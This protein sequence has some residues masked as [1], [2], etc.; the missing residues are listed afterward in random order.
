MSIITV[1]FTSQIHY[2]LPAAVRKTGLKK[3]KA[4]VLQY[5]PFEDENQVKISGC[6]SP[7]CNLKK[8]TRVSIEQ[9]FVAEN[10]ANELLTSVHATLLGIDLPFI[11]VDGTNACDNIYDVNNNKV[12]CPV[13]KG[14]TY[15]YKT[16][17]PILEIYPKSATAASVVS[18][19]KRD[20]KPRSDGTE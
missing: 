7:P 11:G 10:D 15:I 9:T 17:F 19:K 2:L 1:S 18:S 8:K 20:S 4:L 13:K 12:G 5:I 16:D 6:D 14:T 3:A